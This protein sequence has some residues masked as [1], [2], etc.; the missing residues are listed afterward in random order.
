MSSVKGPADA[1]ARRLF[2]A[3]D[4]RGDADGKASASELAA[5][6]AGV[7]NDVVRGDSPSGGV[8]D[9]AH[10]HGS[11]PPHA[12][13]Y[14]RAV[15]SARAGE[16]T[17]LAEPLRRLP[18][19]LRRLA[20]EVDSL[21]G[22][23]DGRVTTAEL[24]RVARF[25]L[26][27]LPFFTKE[28]DAILELAQY[29]GLDAGARTAPSVLGLRLALATV[30]RDGASGAADFRELFDEA[31]RAGE[32]LGLPGMLRDAAQHAPHWHSLSILE[33][34]AVASSAARSLSALLD[35]DWRLA[36]ATMLVHD[37]GKMLERHATAH[38]FSYTDHEA[39]GAEWLKERGVS[40]DVVFHVRHHA[41]LRKA[42]AD[43]LAALCG[44]RE[45]LRQHLLVYVADQIAKGSEP[46]QLA[47]FEEQ[48]PKIADL[49]SRC[50]IDAQELFEARRALVE[51]H[52]GIDP[53]MPLPV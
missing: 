27:A 20:L 38:G 49:A 30:D 48:A 9:V 14:E 41:D 29:L 16:V 18:A 44:T 53:G 12:D 6:R 22:D 42:S 7:T 50:G 15:V 47:S 1:T 21:W 2:A 19:P 32:V 40:D 46:A 11:T 4:L 5:I 51:K 35:V 17:T 3:A 43:E 36:G 8:A 23:A 34:S 26:A 37:V 33:H 24:D 39:L 31:V 52:F 25:T 10:G 28:A 13:A 45:R